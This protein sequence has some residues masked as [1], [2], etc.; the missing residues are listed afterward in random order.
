MRPKNKGESQKSRLDRRA[1]RLA[2]ARL[3]IRDEAGAARLIQEGLSQEGLDELLAKAVSKGGDKEDGLGVAKRALAAG[4]K[5]DHR[6]GWLRGALDECLQDRRWEMATALALGGAVAWM[7]GDDSPLAR[8]AGWGAPEDT[9]A[10][11]ASHGWRLDGEAG[12]SSSPL[13]SAWLTR[14]WETMEALLRMGADPEKALLWASDRQGRYAPLP[15]H[16]RVLLES[17]IEARALEKI[18]EPQEA[19]KARKGHLSL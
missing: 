17:V 1:E 8:A 7:G 11:L 19:P 4:A 3:S 10:A 18:G 14:S 16:G 12:G 2:I 5:P 13:A 6:H 15:E 9:L